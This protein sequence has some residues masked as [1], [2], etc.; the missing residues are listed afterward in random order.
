MR[1]VRYMAEVSRPPNC[2]SALFIACQVARKYTHRLPTVA[3]LRGDYGMHRATAY[4]WIAA[5][6][7]ARC[8][9]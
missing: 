2:D 6:K 9:P 4:R 8:E 3:E 1:A 7:A 5:I